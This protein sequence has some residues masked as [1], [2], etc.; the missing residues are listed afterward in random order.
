MY[1]ASILYHIHFKTAVIVAVLCMVRSN[2]GIAGSNS[3][4]GI[5]VYSYKSS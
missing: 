5:V 1:V 2:T 4:H 3:A